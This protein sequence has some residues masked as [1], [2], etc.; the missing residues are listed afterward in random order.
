MKELRVENKELKD[1]YSETDNT[2]NKISI[3]KKEIN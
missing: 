1:K 3:I 2:V